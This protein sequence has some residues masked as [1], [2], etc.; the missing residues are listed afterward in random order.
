MPSVSELT[1]FFEVSNTLN[2]SLAAKNL[3]ISQ[4]A[5]SRAIQNLESTVGTA[6]FIRHAKGVQLT[7]AGQTVLLQIKPLLQ[8]WQNTKLQALASHH[9]VQGQVKL[10]CHSTVGLFIHGLISELLEKHEALD[11]ELRHAPSEVITQAVIDLKVDIG[12]VTNPIHYPDLIVKKISE[13]DITFWVGPGEREIQNLHSEQAILICDPEVYY[14]QLLLK[15]CKAANIKFKR[16][17]KVNSLEVVASLT[18]NGCG[19]GLL[20][21]CFTRTL[22]ASKLKRIPDAPVTKEDVSLIYRKECL[23]VTAFKTVLEFI[24]EWATTVKNTTP[25]GDFK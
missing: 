23:D 5:L 25:N 16:I 21:S 18:A 1:Y 3:C 9:Q 24:K 15:K 13:K 17:L 4:P 7:P 8:N 20:P 10:G 19:I 12:V 14:T 6:L 22:Y 11:I 2:L